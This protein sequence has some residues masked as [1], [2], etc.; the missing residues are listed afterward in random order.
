[1]S[2]EH[3]GPE[4][5]RDEQGAP[6]PTLAQQ[7]AETLHKA[8]RG[9]GVDWSTERRFS[10]AS[11]KS[12]ESQVQVLHPLA[13]HFEFALAYFEPEVRDGSQY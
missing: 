9:M 1:M 8:A 7:Q 12:L 4:S 10:T 2:V 6:N 3:G 5:E 13:T 11:W